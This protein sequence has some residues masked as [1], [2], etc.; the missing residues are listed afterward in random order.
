VAEDE[1]GVAEGQ[2]GAGN[3]PLPPFRRQQVVAGEQNEGIEGHR[4]E[5]G[6]RIA[7]YVDVDQMERCQRVSRSGEQAG[8]VT[9]KPAARQRKRRPGSH[10]KG[11][12]LGETDCQHVAG[13]E[14]AEQRGDVKAKRSVVVEK[15]IAVAV[16]GIGHPAH[17]EMATGERGAQL[18]HPLQQKGTVAT[19]T[20][21]E[22]ARAGKQGQ[23]GNRRQKEGHQ[24]RRR[25]RKRKARG[26]AGY[27]PVAGY[28]APPHPGPSFTEGGSRIAPPSW[29]S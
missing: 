24:Q 29:C 8:A 23:S 10:Q 3:E 12:K 28:D 18:L 6:Q 20:G 11:G 17:R 16:V 5:L 25:S 7:A 1:R 27:A 21:I 9:F 2:R 22:Q 4:P 15:R 14:K 19:A 13:T 26:E